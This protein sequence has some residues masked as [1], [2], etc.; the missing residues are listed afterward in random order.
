MEAI[1][2]VRYITNHS[3][4]EDGYAIAR[5]AALRG[6]Q[7]TLVSGP[8]SLPAP[9]FCEDGEYSERQTDV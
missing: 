1:D 9:L 4:R 3:H 5:V 6:A 2:P 8:T 7:V